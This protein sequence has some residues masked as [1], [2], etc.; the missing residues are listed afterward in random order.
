MGR[1]PT[2]ARRAARERAVQC[3]FGLDFTNNDVGEALALFWEST[4]ARDAVRE[5][6]EVLV[7]GVM[8]NLAELDATIVTALDNWTP[9][10]VGRIERNAIRVALYEMRHVND[11]DDGVAINEAIEVARRFGSDEA[12]RFVNA[13]LDRLKKG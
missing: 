4:P 1:I 11:V 7:L 13:V 12:P 9:E 5:Y 3:L 8:E 6:A 10:R 2:S